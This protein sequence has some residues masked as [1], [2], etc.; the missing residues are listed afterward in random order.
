MANKTTES[1]GSTYQQIGEFWDGHDATEFGE[2]T[3]VEFK[4][5]IQ[6]Q[7]RYYPVD[8]TLSSKIREVAINRGISE[9]TLINLWLQEK[10]NQSEV[11][12]NVMT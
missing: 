3:H 4:V 5:D 10:I 9:E 2:Q 6:S 12:D 8:C 7:R 1:K 11:E